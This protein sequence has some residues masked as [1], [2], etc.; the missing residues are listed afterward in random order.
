MCEAASIPVFLLHPEI[1]ARQKSIPQVNVLQ[2]ELQ[3]NAVTRAQNR[4]RE[5][6]DEETKTVTLVENWTD[7]EDER[8]NSIYE[9]RK[10]EEMVACESGDYENTNNENKGV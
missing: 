4:R 6:D 5:V 3:M 10:Q 2:E 9:R 1:I 7:N 8:R